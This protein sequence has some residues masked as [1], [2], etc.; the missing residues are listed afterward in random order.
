MGVSKGVVT[1]SV[2]MIISS[3]SGS[4]EVGHQHCAVPYS[5]AGG[6]DGLSAVTNSVSGS[7]GVGS[8]ALSYNVDCGDE[9]ALSAV[10]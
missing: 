4:D 3:S 1:E 10:K 7:L 6:V 9:G 2:S 8:A 5:V